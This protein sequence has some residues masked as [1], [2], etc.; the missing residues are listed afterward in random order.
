MNI[1]AQA[2]DTQGAA[3]PA[4][5][6]PRGAI[7]PRMNALLWTV[8]GLLA[9][10]FLFAGSMKFIMSVEA[11]TQQMPLPG[12]FLHFIGAAEVLGALGL[13]LPGLFRVRRGLTPL[14][15]AGLV[16]IM[17]GATV[18]TASTGPLASAIPPV[19]FGCLAALVAYRR[20]REL[21]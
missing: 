11:M 4:V 5:K 19:V 18:V 3:T 6:P 20:W 21:S 9:L 16:V 14:A 17:I 10:L 1:T 8:Q 15:A 7:S 2:V 12:G 13:I